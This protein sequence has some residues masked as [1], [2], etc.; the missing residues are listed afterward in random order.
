MSLVHC[1][2]ATCLL[3]GQCRKHI[4]TRRLNGI[5]QLG[6]DRVVCLTFGAHETAHHL[7]V[8]LYDKGNVV[9]CNSEYVILS[10]LRPR[11]DGDEV[12]FA[13]HE[14]Y[15]IENAHRIE[16]VTRERYVCGGHSQPNSIACAF[17]PL[18][19]NSNRDIAH[20]VNTPVVGSS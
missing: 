12:K 4:R 18:I 9:L 7:I 3:P 11:T 16:P 13:V 19:G 20:T 2:T 10:L 8:E 6:S 14:R 1:A 15:P 17:F 5:T